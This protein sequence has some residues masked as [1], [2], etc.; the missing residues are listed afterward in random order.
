MRLILNGESVAKFLVHVEDLVPIFT[1]HS[2]YAGTRM[3]VVVAGNGVGKMVSPSQ[4]VTQSGKELDHF[5][6][7]ADIVAGIVEVE[8]QKLERAVSCTA[9]H[10]VNGG[11]YEIDA[12]VNGRNRI[13]KGLLLVVV[14]VNADANL[15]A[16]DV[17]V[18][19]DEIA[20]VI[21]VKRTK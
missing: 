1:A 5:E 12:F 21:G 4:I 15:F 10:A 16:E 17:G 7:G 18:L 19:T 9:A 2:L 11:I 13:G 8:K 3:E 14:A 6:D 20:N